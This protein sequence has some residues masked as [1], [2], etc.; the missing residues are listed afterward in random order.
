MG[1]MTSAYK[2]RSCEKPE[3]NR[4]FAR[5]RRRWKEKIKMH[6]REILWDRDQQQALVNT[7]K[8]ICG[9]FLKN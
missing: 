9:I 5:S 1:D 3:G 8:K 2:N 6:V 7:Q 4:L